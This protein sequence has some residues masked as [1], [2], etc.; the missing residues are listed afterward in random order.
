MCG[1]CKGVVVG[2]MPVSTTSKLLYYTLRNSYDQQPLRCAR[3][4]SPLVVAAAAEA[5]HS[6]VILDQ[7]SWRPIEWTHI[8]A[9]MRGRARTHIGR[10]RVP[11]SS[12]SSLP[13][14]SPGIGG[15]GGGVNE[16]WTR[17]E[18]INADFPLFFCFFGTEKNGR[19]LSLDNFLS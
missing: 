12:L 2:S 9:I 11:A 1:L 16:N 5:C 6:N 19:F 7:P 8:T 14:P 15:E 4:Q 17:K 13:P 10:F 18:K 3:L